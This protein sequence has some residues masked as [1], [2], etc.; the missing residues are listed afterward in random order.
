MENMEIKKILVTGCNGYIGTVLVEK[1]IKQKYI[2]TGLDTFFY[3]NN[4]IGPVF[5]SPYLTLVQKDVRKIHEDDVKGFDAI[6][7]LAALSNDPIGEFSPKLTLDINHKAS[8]T[9]AKL[10]KKV[11]VQRFIFPSSCSIYGIAEKGVV[12]ESSPVN[13]LTAYAMSKA[14]VE[15]DLKDLAD[16]DF[17]VGLMRNST[18]YGFSS[19]LRSD[20]VVN[21][22]VTCALAQGKIE[23]KSD[24]TPWRPLIDVRDLSEI[25]IQ[26]L[27]ASREETNGEIINIGFNENNFQVKDL[28][29][30]IQKN[31]PNS[32]VD[33]TG[34]HGAD[35]RS[36]KVIF[37]KFN[38]LFP[39]IK[40]QWTI[41]KSVKDLILQLR[42]NNFSKED[43][44]S[45]KYARLMILKDLL[46][47]KKVTNM[48]YWLK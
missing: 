37:D 4:S 24:G 20:L 48:L 14:L 27:H 25:M 42:N 18:V 12:D 7:H 16:K 36:Y 35:A 34:E 47:N 8:I 29:E 39:H 21:N 15:R 38:K 32:I 31:I 3:K 43:F 45:G 5:S 40:Q 11:G 2:V 41:D 10:A 46:K 19:Q 44:I 23:V 33:Y 13:A 17:Y 9:L 30:V 1:L 6:I 22:F 26:F 28:L